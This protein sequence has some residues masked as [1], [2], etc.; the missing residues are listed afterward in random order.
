MRIS[1]F[2]PRCTPENSHGRYVI[3]LAKRIAIDHS[4]TVHAGAFWHP[5][6]SIAQ[7]RLL[8]IPN[9]PAVARLATLW[10]ASACGISH[11]L[12]D[13]V[14]TQGADAPVGNIV[15]AQFCNATMKNQGTWAGFARRI[16]YTIGAAAEKYC[17]SK[18]STERIIAISQ[19]VKA[20]I[21]L[22]YGVESRRVTVIHHGVDTEAFH[23]RHRVAERVP[24]RKRLGLGPED[25]VVLF[26][27]GDYRRK[28]LLALLQ[29]AKLVGERLKVLAVGVEPD[30]ALRRIVSDGGL[31]DLVSFLGTTGDIAPI[32]AVADC[33]ALPTVYDTFSMATLEA[34]ACGLPVIVSRAAGVAEILSPDNDSLV[35]ERADDVNLLAQ[36]LTRLMRDR[37]LRGRLGDQARRTA[38]RHSWDEVAKATLVVY[39]ETTAARFRT[40]RSGDSFRRLPDP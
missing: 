12:A 3:E 6:R 19:Q 32:Y 10:T 39:Q 13:I 34:M 33:F 30:S 8:P 4:V 40:S 31:A 24:G 2:V 5:M 37:D 9:R 14:H 35:L 36:H 11:R 20:E 38:E 27:G 28:G 15:T 26:I 25:F 7:C 21:E 23:T 18:R 22:E 17:M 29:A 16:N 1:F